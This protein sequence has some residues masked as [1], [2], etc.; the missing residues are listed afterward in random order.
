MGGLRE[1]NL[2]CD[3]GSEVLVKC[4]E[5]QGSKNSGNTLLGQVMTAHDYCHDIVVAWS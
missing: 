4:P 2:V 1:R 3:H 5:G